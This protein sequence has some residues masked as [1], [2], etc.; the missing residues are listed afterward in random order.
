MKTDDFLSAWGWSAVAGFKKPVVGST[1]PLK[2]LG[3]R[4]ISYWDLRSFFWRLGVV[5]Y[6]SRPISFRGLHQTRNLPEDGLMSF[7]V[8]RH[9]EL[10]PVLVETDEQD[11]F[12][13]F[14]VTW[15][16]VVVVVV[17]STPKSL[18][19]LLKNF[20][21]WDL[22][23]APVLVPTYSSTFFQFFP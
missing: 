15:G 9:F 2:S 13:K 18:W 8:K 11:H 21:A 10:L 3:N 1:L 16:L 20:W 19:S 17:F 23:C 5:F 6:P 7:D 22:I 4:L 12:L 14:P